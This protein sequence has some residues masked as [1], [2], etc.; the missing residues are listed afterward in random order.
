VQIV[1][2]AIHKKLYSELKWQSV[3]NYV[4]KVFLADVI[5]RHLSHGQLSSLQLL[6][7]TK[8]PL[9]ALTVL[10]KIC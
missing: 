2:Y 3:D 8:S 4:R 1:F 7:S 5:S 9:V 6:N 10:K